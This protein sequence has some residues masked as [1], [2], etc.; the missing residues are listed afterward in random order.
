VPVLGRQAAGFLAA[1]LFLAATTGGGD[2]SGAPPTSGSSRWAQRAQKGGKRPTPK[3]AKPKAGG[4]RKPVEAPPARPLS[5]DLPLWTRHLSGGV[6][7]VAVPSATAQIVAVTVVEGAGAASDPAGRGGLA[8][9]RARLDGAR[10]S[11]ER[12]AALVTERGGDAWV[13]VEREQVVARYVL[14]AG[15]LALPLWLEADRLEARVSE[16]TLVGSLRAMTEA[17]D[18]DPSVRQRGALD[19]LVYSGLAPYAHDPDGTADELLA[20]RND[21]VAGTLAP[22]PP[23][24]IVVVITGAITAERAL[25]DADAQL[26]GVVARPAT[27]PSVALPDQT[28][29]READ[30]TDA[31]TAT[32]SLWVGFAIP[33][34]SEADHAALEVAAAILANGPRSRLERALIDEGVA[35]GVRAELERRR[36]PSELRIAV[37]LAPGADPVRARELT[38]RLLLELGKSA[39]PPDEVRRA[40]AWLVEKRVE[41]LADP[42]ALATEVA[43]AALR[44]PEA[45]SGPKGAV[46]AEL[47]RWTGTNGDAVARAVSKHLSPIRRNVVEV[48]PEHPLEAPTGPSLAKPAPRRGAGA[49][50]AKGAPK[51][52]P[53]KL[54]PAKAPPAKGQPAAGA[55]A[56]PTPAAAPPAKGTRGPAKKRGKP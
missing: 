4:P 41:T 46:E 56:K 13:E 55:P 38:E 52:A 25:L 2:A 39:P 9:L 45:F 37:D 11:A 44:D 51:A 19:A 14:P 10:A 6:L 43:R 32:G 3:P 16:A 15:E 47:D 31:R 50:P 36:G 26:A 18:R 12:R 53:A 48:A 49:A 33:P 28:N 17:R 1:A 7:V 54:Q 20:I 40:I 27:A 42:S 30:L 29:Q 22:R 35:R 21:A 8:S 24:P 34:G 23:R 5:I